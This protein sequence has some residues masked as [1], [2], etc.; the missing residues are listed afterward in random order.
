MKNFLQFSL[1]IF[2]GILFSNFSF[3]QA[4]LPHHDPLNYTVSQGLQSQTGWTSLNSG[5]DLLIASGN[6]SSN[7]LP[8][9][10]GNKVTFDGSGIDAAKLFTQQTSGTTYFS[11]LMNITSLGSLNTTGG[12]FTGFTEGTTNTFGATVWTRS[13]GSGFDIGINPKTT[14]ANTVWTSGTTS[15]NTTIFVVISYQIVS[16][17]TN[18]VVKLWINPATGG[19]EPSA[20]LSATNGLTDLANINR[21]LIRQDGASATPYIEMDELRI[22]TTWASVT[23]APSTTVTQLTNGIASSPLTASATNKAVLGFSISSTGTPNLTAFNVATSTTSVSKFTNIKLYRSTDNDYSTSGDNTEITG[24][25]INQTA[26]QL[27]F[28]GLTEALS[29]SAKNYFVVV[30]IHSSVSG[31]TPS[32]EPSLTNSNVTVSAGTVNSFTLTG[33]DYSFSGSGSPTLTPGSL[34]A[35]GSQCINST[36]G[37]NSFSLSGS[38]LDNSSITVGPLTGFTFAT[39]SGGSYGSSITLT[40]SGTDYTYGSGSLTG[41]TIYVKFNPT[42]VQSYGGTGSSGISISGGGASTVYTDC[43]GSGVNTSPSVTTPTSSSVTTT[44]ATLG[45]NI[46]SIGCSNATERGVY[47]STTNG[48]TPPGQGTK[49]YSSGSFGTGVFTESVTG[50]PSGTTIYYRAFATNNGGNG[51]TSQSSFTTLK[52]EPTNYPTS[53][54]CGTTTTTTIPLTWTDA[55]GTTTPDGYLIKWSS[56][57]YAAITAPSDGTSESDALG[58]SSSGT[59][60]I[61]QGTQVYTVGSGTSLTSGTTYYIKVWSY[62]NSG[63]SIDYKTSSEPQTSC[64]TL[65]GPCHTEN[66]SGIG[67]S[68]TYGTRNWTGEGGS[69]S[70]TDAR[71]DQTITGKAITVRSGTLTSPTFTDGVGSITVS[72]KFPFSESSGDLVFKVNGNTVG[73]ILYSDMNGS[74]PITKTFNGVNVGGNSV[75]T[76]VSSGARYTIDD[77]NWTCYT[78]CTA[79]TAASSVSASNPTTDGFDVGW[80]AGGGDGTMIVVT[81]GTVAAPVSGTTYTANTSWAS[82]GQINTNN[83]VVFRSSGSSVTG[84]TGLNTETQ[85]TITA[86]EYYNTDVCYNLTSPPSNTKWTLSSEPNSHAASFTSTPVEYNKIDLSFSAAS[87]ITNADGYIIIQKTG[88]APTG[89]PT[90]A[91]GYTVGNTIGDAT[92]AAIITSSSATSTSVT[93]LTGSTNYYFML[94]PFNWNGANSPTYNYRTA[95]TIPVTNATTLV[96]PA[97]TS[98]IIFNSSSP[99]SQNQNIAYIDYQG[100]TLTNTGTGTNGSIGVMGITVRDF[101]GDALPT[102][103]TG[104][105]FSVTNVANI[106]SARMFNGNSPIGSAVAVNGSSPIVFT[107]LSESCTNNSTLALNLRVTFLSTVT[108]KH[109]MVFT[110]TSATAATGSTSSLFAAADAGGAVSENTG[111]DINRIQVTADRLGF[112]TQPVQTAVNASMSAVTVEGKDALGN[113]DLDYTGSIDITSDGTM[114]PTPR[115]A[116]A[117]SGLATWSTGNGNAIIH[118]ALATGRQLTATTTGLGYSNTATSNLFNID[119]TPGNSYRTTSAGTWKSDGSGTA[120]W[121]RLISG[122]WTSNSSPSFSSSNNIYIRHYVSITGSASPYN[123]IIENNGKLTNSSS[124]TYGTSLLVQKGGILQVNA[125]L[126]VSGIFEVEDSAY[127]N[128]NFE[129]GTPSSSIWSG[130]E[131]FHPKSFIVF[132]DWD[133]ANDDLISSNTVITTN[134]YNG[135]TAAFGNVILDFESNLGSSDDWIMLTSGTNINLAHGNLIFRSNAAANLADMR[136]STT[137]TVTSGIGGDF[138]VE[139]TYIGAVFINFKTSGTLDFTIK[140]N[141][142]LDAGTTRIM[143]GSVDGSSST[144]TVEGNINITSS[145]VLDMNS[146]S[147]EGPPPPIAILNLKGDLTVSSGG[148]LQNSNDKNLGLFNFSGTGDG[149][150]S[151]LTQT[152]DVASTSS[153][154]NR[155]V[156]FSVK[157]GAYVQQISRD[158]ELGTNSGLVVDS[159]GVYDFGFNGST[160]L[161]VKNSGSQTGAYFTSS[162]SSTLKITSPDG[163]STTTGVGNVQIAAANRTYTKPAIYWYIGKENQLMGNVITTGGNTNNSIIAELTNNSTT[164]TPNNN[165]GISNTASPFDALGGRLDIRKGV[166]I[167]TSSATIVG[168]GRLVMTDGT[169]R[170][171]VLSTTLPQL[172]NY[173]NYSL[174]GGTVELNG[175]GDQTLRGGTTPVYYNVKISGTNTLGTNKKNITS[176]LVINN[177]LEVTENGIFDT[178]VNGITGNA[179]LTMS[180]NGRWRIS[181]TS[182]TTLPE[183]LGISTPYSLT[184]GT[185]EL[186]GSVSGGSYVPQLI[187]GTANN[188]NI[189]YYNVVINASSMNTDNGNVGAQA[190]FSVTNSLTVN[191]PA[192]LILGVTDYVEGGGSF[193]INNNAGLYYGNVNGIKTGSG[194]V[195]ATDGNVLVTGTKSFGLATYGFV[196]TNTTMESGNGLPDTVKNLYVL[197]TDASHIVNLTNDVT[198][199]DT[200]A[201]SKGIITTGTKKVIVADTA[202]S[203]IIALGTNI[204]TNYTNSYING[205]LTRYFR[206]SSSLTY[207]FPVGNATKGRLATVKSN[208]L[209]GKTGQNPYGIRKFNASFKNGP[210]ATGGF[211]SDQ[212]MSAWETSIPGVPHTP[213]KRMRDEGTWIIEPDSL[214]TQGSYD[215]SLFFNG[216]TSPAALKDNQF[217]ILKRDVGSTTFADWKPAGGTLSSASGPGRLESNGYALRKGLSSF[218]EFGIGET[219]NLLPIQLTTFTVEKCNDDLDALL[220]WNTASELNNDRFDVELALDIKG[221]LTFS[222]IGEVKGTGT[223]TA[224]NNYSFIDRQLDKSGNRYYRLKQIDFDGSYEFTEVRVLNFNT[225]KLEVSTLYPN[226]TDAMLNFIVSAPYDKSVTISVTNIIGQEVFF[227]REELMKGVTTLRFD[228][229]TLAQGVYFLNVKDGR[230]VNIHRKF[231]KF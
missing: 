159:A 173:S 126:T 10:S 53:L 197:K 78:P 186:Y 47:W 230:D 215:I 98:D 161:L 30:D 149:S 174:T 190:S 43:T 203:S 31:S 15:I 114:S 63:S 210:V 25:T 212:Y 231:E 18:D 137:G 229:S 107:G 59:K 74:T 228:V 2:A 157:K 131:N 143:A 56:T 39:T 125:S 64:A 20:T 213:Y 122:V 6:L 219:D 132:Q 218:S 163:I 182:N 54:S 188:A 170:T 49:V 81:S 198:I 100:T 92:V 21:I 85:Y 172:S 169:F 117:S 119:N 17:T 201:L 84:I 195:R 79:P 121:E 48:F 207:Y 224:E 1:L 152:I 22:G 222:K 38:N 101:G 209:S 148:L 220:K 193:T 185:F 88:S 205:N 116:T 5:D 33:T 16:G 144:V 128:I 13:D 211:Q 129:F 175:N 94:I 4:T 36:Y 138:I 44:T 160:A 58:S 112:V 7:S 164:L 23:P 111:G 130:T 179:G 115:N 29:S 109:K 103:L 87:T 151:N 134:A 12:Y 62:T 118:T 214:A 142:Q 73:T 225:T 140:G 135:Y 217:G 202:A 75:I 91:T 28:S 171:S 8:A 216:F 106:R 60:N 70:A 200:L 86:Y 19:S 68:S 76:A 204:G 165:I 65:S 155:Y 147:A 9:S 183:L 41:C 227:S 51:F 167:E 127:V 156:K 141:M 102:I 191:S 226:P 52:T 184:G 146:T 93:G 124:C 154:E 95:A 105:T 50:L 223:S 55:T 46:T 120:T 139:D 90:D 34:T 177:N 133:C 67:S 194:T 24:I 40:T 181:K 166:V 192:I 61:G 158:F 27:Q 178:D 42:A 189:T 77:L 123:V 97:M 11:F 35:F 66:F 208:Y 196:S 69:W 162:Q 150:S 82:A 145:A 153:N 26:T 37:P 108:D 83:R 110:I 113:R 3:G 104:I 71:E 206:D 96:T 136:I 168:S 80:T 221:E 180:S 176:S 32:V 45:G 72:A 199:N 187:R 57:S 99:S 89:T 14:A